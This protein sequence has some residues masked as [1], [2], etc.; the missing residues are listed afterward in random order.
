M[1]TQGIEPLA[2]GLNA[3]YYNITNNK[4]LLDFGAV[5]NGKTND[6]SAFLK[7]IS[8]VSK[9]SSKKIIIPNNYFFI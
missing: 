3:I 8:T 6:S 1:F 4:S 9:Q 5:G 7:A 2:Q